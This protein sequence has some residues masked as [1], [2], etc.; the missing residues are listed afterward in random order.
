M[1]IPL[2]RAPYSGYPALRKQKY[3]SSLSVSALA[4]REV[5]FIQCE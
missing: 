3:E 1:K 5:G 4:C 2:Q